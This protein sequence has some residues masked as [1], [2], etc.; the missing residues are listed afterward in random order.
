MLGRGLRR[1]SDQEAIL[2]SS[3]EVFLR[4]LKTEIRGEEGE[5]LRE[6]ER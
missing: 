4:Y 2:G 3:L 5:D 6:C 1:I